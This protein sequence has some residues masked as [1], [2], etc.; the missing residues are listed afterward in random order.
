MRFTYILCSLLFAACVGVLLIGCGGGGSSASATSNGTVRVDGD[1]LVFTP[2]NPAVVISAYAEFTNTTTAGAKVILA[3][4]MPVD[5]KGTRKLDLK[6]LTSGE[7]LPPHPFP[8]YQP[9]L[10]YLVSGGGYEGDDTLDTP[11]GTFTATVYANLDSNGA[12]KKET[13]ATN[14]PVIM[15]T[16]GSQQQTM[17]VAAG[18]KATYTLKITHDGLDNDDDPLTLPNDA[19][20]VFAKSSTTTGW[21]VEYFDAAH[22]NVT[23]QVSGSGWVVPAAGATQL[24]PGDSIIMTIEV[25]PNITQSAGT[26]QTLMLAVT[27]THDTQRHDA[28]WATTVVE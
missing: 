26:N 12:T 21:Q 18:T 28:F 19:F 25:T 22:N 2:V 13:I 16:P 17:T 14:V 9:D 27:S 10:Q 23:A 20:N 1:Y 15:L 3:F 24:K 6:L 5:V 8:S 7:G 11:T 4:G